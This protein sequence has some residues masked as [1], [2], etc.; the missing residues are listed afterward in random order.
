[1][2]NKLFRLNQ[3]EA[4]RDSVLKPAPSRLL[5]SR[6]VIIDAGRNNREPIRTNNR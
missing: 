6:Q 2:L 3:Q 1:M 5:S 4:S